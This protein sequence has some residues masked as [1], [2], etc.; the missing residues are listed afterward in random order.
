MCSLQGVW[1]GDG[2][3]TLDFTED[4]LTWVAS[5]N[6]GATVV[7]GVEVIELRN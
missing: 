4:D 6:Y 1:G 3:G 2:N 7:L 5:K